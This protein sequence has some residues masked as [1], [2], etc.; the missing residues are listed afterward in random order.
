MVSGLKSAAFGINFAL[1][2]FTS[3]TSKL[4][5]YGANIS[6][7]LI[8]LSITAIYG[9]TLYLNSKKPTRVE[10][11]SEIQ[12]QINDIN[13]SIRDSQMRDNLGAAKKFKW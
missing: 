5:I 4:I 11:N 8:F 3:Y 9:Y 12:A 7:A 10:I 2:G 1:L 6:D 13:K